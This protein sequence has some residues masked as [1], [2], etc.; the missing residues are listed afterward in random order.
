MLTEEKLK[1]L[2]PKPQAFWRA[3]QEFVVRSGQWAWI[4]AGTPKCR[5]WEQY[6]QNRGWKPFAIKQIE[7]KLITGMTMPTEWPEWFDSNYVV[8]SIAAE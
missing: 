1:Q 3:A 2:S 4:E 6:F 8:R 5:A 7:K